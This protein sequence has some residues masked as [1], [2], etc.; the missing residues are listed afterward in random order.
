MGKGRKGHLGEEK[1]EEGEVGNGERRREKS[2]WG[3]MRSRKEG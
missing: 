1:G 3:R 2:L